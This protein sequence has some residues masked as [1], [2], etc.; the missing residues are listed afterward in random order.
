MADNLLYHEEKK[1]K[2]LV[3]GGTRGFGKEVSNSLIRKGYSIITV[4]R[5][6]NGLKNAIHYHCD[7]ENTGQWHKTIQR[8]LVENK[9]KAFFFVVGYAKAVEFTGLTAKDWNDALSRNF[10]YIALALQEI[11]K[12]R[13]GEDIKIITIG[14]QWSYRTGNSK[15][16]PYTISKHAV[17]TLMKDFSERNKTMQANHYCVPTM[18]TPGYR[19]VRESFRK[20]GKMEG[21]LNQPT[22]ESKEISN[23]VVDL[24]L[25]SRKSGKTYIIHSKERITIL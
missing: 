18:D 14:S 22:E 21:I 15:L 9:I 6:K 20:L 11:E 8:V 10:L 5:S 12:K 3:V 24:A 16:I 25:E 7:V 2:A 13:A 19:K 1:M 4:S 17:S 23:A